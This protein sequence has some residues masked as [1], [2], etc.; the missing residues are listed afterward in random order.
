MKEDIERHYPE[1]ASAGYDKTSDET[2]VY[3]CIAWAAGDTSH[4]GECGEDGPLEHPGVY[5][6][7][8]AKHGYDLDAL[9]SAYSTLGFEV[10]ETAE[11]E[12]GFKKIALYKE[13]NEWR[14][15]S[16]LLDD[17]RWSSKLG[18][19]EDVSH[20][21]PTDA[22]GKCNGSVACYMRRGTQS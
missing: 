11:Y 5:W 14:H 9:V 22:E 15:A 21:M 1:L 12:H 20:A 8:I 4:W 13:G 19:L 17:G 2:V 3:N 10:C 6:P 7:P 16:K 18:D